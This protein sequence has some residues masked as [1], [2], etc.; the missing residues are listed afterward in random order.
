MIWP[1]AE[2]NNFSLHQYLQLDACSMLHDI[3]G[4]LMSTWRSSGHIFSG[5]LPPIYMYAYSIF[6]N[7]LDV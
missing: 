7:F 3:I 2:L 5:F 4:L 6:D 1:T